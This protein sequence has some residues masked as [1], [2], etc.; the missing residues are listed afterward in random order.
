MTEIGKRIRIERIIN[1]ITGNTVIVP[2]DHG[3]SIGPVRGLV[4]LPETIDKV[5]NGGANAVV[6]QKGMVKAGHRGYG[7]D[8]GLIIHLSASTSLAPDPNEKVLVTEVVEAIKLGADAVSVH[9]NIGSNTEAEQLRV[10]GKVSA[11]CEEWGMPLLAMMYPRGPSITN[12]YDPKIVAHVARAG[13]ELGADIVKTNYTGDPRSFKEVVEGC[14]VPVVIAG[15][16]KMSSDEDV[17]K[18]VRGAMDAGARGVAIGRN[19]FQHDD[20]EKMT[21][22]IAMIVHENVDVKTAMEVLK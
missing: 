16:P 7:R 21:R 15:G 3:I 8:I 13:A 17:L 10:L 22:A 2:M 20:P 11:E 5:A 9:I 1:R 4:N 12:P 18:M 19:I 14:P 6:Q